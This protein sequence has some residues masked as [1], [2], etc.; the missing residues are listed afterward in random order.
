MTHVQNYFGWDVLWRA[1]QRIRAIPSFQ[2]FDKAEVC[3]LN[4]ARILNEDILR[5]QV[6]VNQ[7]LPMHILEGQHDLSSVEPD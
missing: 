6:P 2:S 1:T 3:Q 4:E 7:V 5:L